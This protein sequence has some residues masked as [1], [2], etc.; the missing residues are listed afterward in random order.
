MVTRDIESHQYEV[1]RR[2]PSRTDVGGPGSQP[3]QSQIWLRY[4]QKAENY[5]GLLKLA[6]CLLWFRRYLR[7]SGLKESLSGRARPMRGSR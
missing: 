4:E 7:L 2:S 6:C 5:L 3:H 1:S